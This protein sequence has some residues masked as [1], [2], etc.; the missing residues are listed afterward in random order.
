MFTHPS[1]ATRFLRHEDGAVQMLFVSILGRSCWF[2][3]RVLGF[4]APQDLLDSKLG[5]SSFILVDRGPKYCNAQMPTVLSFIPQALDIDIIATKI[6]RSK[7]HGCILSS[8]CVNTQRLS[9]Q[10][11]PYLSSSRQ[12]E[13]NQK[14]PHDTP[15][16]CVHKSPVTLRP[17]KKR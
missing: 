15:K 3:H 7:L 12:A 14:E 16:G 6:R 13:N 9:H 2:M 8:H 17:L 10:L 5:T 4:F 1:L 11:H